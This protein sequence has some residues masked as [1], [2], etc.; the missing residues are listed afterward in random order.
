MGNGSREGFW[1]FRAEQSSDAT[2]ATGRRGWN[3]I[4]DKEGDARH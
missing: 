2:F 3:E 4:T 1:R